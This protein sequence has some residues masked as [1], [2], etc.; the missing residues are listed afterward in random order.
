MVVER[1]ERTT[2]RIPVT[3]AF[4]LAFRFFSFAAPQLLS[5]HFIL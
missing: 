2:M 1:R 5:L 4:G 3:G